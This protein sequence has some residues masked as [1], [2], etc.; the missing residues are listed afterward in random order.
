MEQDAI[1]YCCRGSEGEF[2][3]PIA[4]LITES[5]FIIMVEEE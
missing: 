1:G 2:V 5:G 4:L 3:D